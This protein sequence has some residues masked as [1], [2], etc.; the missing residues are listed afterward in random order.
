MSDA[1]RRARALVAEALELVPDQVP[2][3]ASI[4]GFAKWDSLGH[5][6]VVARLEEALGRPLET[7]E[8]LAVADLA[9]IAALLGRGGT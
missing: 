9:S 1:D 6:R 8:V 4:D 5:L 7:D 3:D 2:L